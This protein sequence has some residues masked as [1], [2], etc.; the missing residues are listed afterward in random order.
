VQEYP[1]IAAAK[2]ARAAAGEGMFKTTANV[3]VVNIGSPV[4]GAAFYPGTAGLRPPSQFTGKRFERP[5]TMAEKR[6]I[7]LLGL[8]VAEP[9]HLTAREQAVVNMLADQNLH[10]EE[11]TQSTS[12]L[13][14]NDD[15]SEGLYAREASDASVIKAYRNGTLNLVRH[16]PGLFLPM[17]QVKSMV[18][19]GSVHHFARRAH[20]DQ[21]Q[22]AQAVP[23]FAPSVSLLAGGG[24]GTV[25][26][27][28]LTSLPPHLRGI[29][30][31]SVP[32]STMVWPQAR[33]SVPLTLAGGTTSARPSLSSIA[34][35]QPTVSSTASSAPLRNLSSTIRRPFSSGSS[36]KGGRSR[37]RNRKMRKS[38]KTRK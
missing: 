38:S 8:P 19:A 6:R 2:E 22:A 29:S 3:R 18:N 26:T 11:L 35:Q 30:S 16:Q 32:A 31:S 14:I 24:A 34:W 27:Q 4:T 28:S 21:L 9:Q 1:K 25:P 37:K 23:S 13:N 7:Q 20:E 33:G 36:S 5:L 17:Q 12:E 15:E 10:N